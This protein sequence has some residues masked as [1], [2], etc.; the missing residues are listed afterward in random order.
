V[1][2]ECERGCNA[3]LQLQPEMRSFGGGKNIRK[4]RRELYALS[5]A[6]LYSTNRA[7]INEN[8]SISEQARSE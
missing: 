7:K 3:K 8:N 4:E 5:A 6:I 2:A 1:K